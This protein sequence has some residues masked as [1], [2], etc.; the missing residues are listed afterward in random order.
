M[1]GSPTV[2]HSLF[3]NHSCNAVGGTLQLSASKKVHRKFQQKRHECCEL[4]ETKQ[5][6]KKKQAS[7]E[8]WNLARKYGWGKE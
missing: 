8:N 2:L 5:R 6:K 3:L 1:Y 7:N 4:G